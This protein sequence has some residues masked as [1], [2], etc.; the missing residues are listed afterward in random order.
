MPAFNRVLGRRRL[1]AC[2]L[3]AVTAFLVVLLAWTA[4]PV[5]AVQPTTTT[6]VV[7]NPNSSSPRLYATV[8]TS[9]GPVPSD[10][11]TVTFYD[12]S[13]ALGSDLVGGVSGI[14]SLATSAF[15]AGA[16]SITATYNGTAN[17][18]ASTSSPALINVVPGGLHVFVSAPNSVYGQN[19]SLSA[20]V[21]CTN[22][23]LPTG[24]IIFKDGVAVLGAATLN[25]NPSSFG[26]QATLATSA[27]AGGSHVITANYSGDSNYAPNTGSQLIIVLKA[28]QTISFSKP[29]D[30]TFSP[31]ATVALVASTTSGLPVSFF[32]SCSGAFGLVETLSEIEVTD[33]YR[34]N[35]AWPRRHQGAAGRS[36][37]RPTLTATARA[38]RKVQ[39]Q[40][41]G[42]SPRSN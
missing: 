39:G 28:S 11:G 2:Q 24:T 3:W 13:T 5:A 17:F 19:A 27:L 36:S 20:N 41:E 18:L 9:S 15:S 8:A 31:G 37:R 25:P 12:G 14:A 4:T 32:N 30:Q 16:H 38:G 26:S 34:P 35:V 23:A 10:G 29:P 1:G 40:D 42:T 6:V 22:D 7:S 33:E 21:C